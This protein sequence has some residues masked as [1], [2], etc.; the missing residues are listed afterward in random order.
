MSKKRDKVQSQINRMVVRR[1]LAEGLSI[2]KIAKL[3]GLSY[4]HTKLLAGQEQ[5]A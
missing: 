1:L 2:A 3:T 5:T 4:Q